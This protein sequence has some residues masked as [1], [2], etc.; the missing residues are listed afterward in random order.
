MSGL[1]LKWYKA[2]TITFHLDVAVEVLKQGPS[3]LFGTD[4]PARNLTVGLST[5]I[6]NPN[7]LDPDPQSG[8]NVVSRELHTACRLRALTQDWNS[9]TVLRALSR[10]TTLSSDLDRGHV[11]A[12]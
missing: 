12:K 3:Y 8:F 11:E 5:R 4:F 9:R 7:S 6:L 1:F 10:S 2:N